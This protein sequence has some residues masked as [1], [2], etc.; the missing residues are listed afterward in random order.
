MNVTSP[1]TVDMSV[2]IN[3]MDTFTKLKQLTA[4]QPFEVG[5][6][7][8]GRV[9]RLKGLETHELQKDFWR[10]EKL[11]DHLRI[12]IFWKRE[13]ISNK[14]KQPDGTIK[15]PNYLEL[16]PE[17]SLYQFTS[18]M[19]DNMSM[20]QKGIEEYRE[21]FLE[22]ED[23]EQLEALC[24]NFLTRPGLRQETLKDAVRGVPLSEVFLEEAVNKQTMHRMIF[25]V[26]SVQVA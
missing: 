11:A 21:Q 1:M 20:K 10:H 3:M 19:N 13:A 8:N 9:W 5:N 7:A 24:E 6:P 25:L 15:A 12:K 16:H 22:R 17:C 14:Y 4:H 18:L 26:P 23:T 2:P